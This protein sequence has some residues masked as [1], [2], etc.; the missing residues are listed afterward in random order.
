MVYSP[1]F[2]TDA[3]A[4][5]TEIRDKLDALIAAQNGT[6]GMV[7][8]VRDCVC[9]QGDDRYPEDTWAWEYAYHRD[10]DGDDA[11]FGHDWLIAEDSPRKPAILMSIQEQCKDD[12]GNYPEGIEFRRLT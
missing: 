6:T 5:L 12:D 8:Q 3:I 4:L 2:E 11:V 7:A 1:G 9:N 10:L